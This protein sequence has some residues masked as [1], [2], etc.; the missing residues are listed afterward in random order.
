MKLGTD[1][2]RYMEIQKIGRD[3]FDFIWESRDRQI[4][5]GWWPKIQNE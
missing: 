4:H 5:N 3:N 2:H 1:N